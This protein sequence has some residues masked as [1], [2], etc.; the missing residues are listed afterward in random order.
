[1]GID[2][3]VRR[4]VPALDQDL[5]E[6]S[7]APH[8]R[9]QNPG[10][11]RRLRSAIGRMLPSAIQPLVQECLI[12]ARL[13]SAGAIPESGSD[14][15][16]TVLG[17]LSSPTGLGEGARLCAANLA[18][19]GF[20]VGMIDAAP[21]LGI[22]SGVQ[23]PGGRPELIVGDAG[24]PLIC[25][26][27]P[28]DLANALMALGL[29]G[30]QRK[31]IGYWAW[32]LPRVPPSW[33]RAF[34]LVHEV[35]APSTFVA[36]ALSASHCTVPILVVPHPLR[37][38]AQRKP[39]SMH[40]AA[41]L[42]ILTVFAY[43]SGFDRKNPLGAIAAF[44]HAFGDREDV[45]LIIKV[46]GSSLSGDPER[47]LA[48]E[49]DGARNIV[50][51]DRVL[52][53][54]GM[55]ELLRSS[56]ILLSLHRAEGFGIPLGQA[57]LMGMPVVATAWSGNLEFMSDRAAC[58]VPVTLVPANDETTAYRGLRASW[59]EPSVE[60]A[61]DW[62]RRLEDPALRASIGRSARAYAADR[63]GLPAFAAAVAPSLGPCRPPAVRPDVAR[64][65]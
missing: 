16:V 5:V 57:M 53:H 35:W 29:S 45:R 8:A 56:D 9:T 48:A 32:E 59:A 65:G 31:L 44:R 14:R 61:A 39:R 37:E 2:V 28:P 27:N 26:I 54:P 64:S 20:T 22:P 30:K 3:P 51:M 36:E 40:A 55:V 7:S 24:G 1:M 33:R 11:I 4:S 25:H 47:R 41:P 6:Q 50:V 42:T 46:R 17:F 13:P 12:R 34:R 62:L 43:K 49:V 19:L 10:L 15:R 38:A 23:L 18:E 60:A 21:L 63:L 52:D 58:L